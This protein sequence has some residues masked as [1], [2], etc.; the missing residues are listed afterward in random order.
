M[1]LQQLLA[2]IEN[3]AAG[4][5]LWVRLLQEVNNSGFSLAPGP[6]QKSKAIFQI[7]IPLISL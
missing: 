7:L 1:F 2:A 3:S 4:Q 5:R 6:A